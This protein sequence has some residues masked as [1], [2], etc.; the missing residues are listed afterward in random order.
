MLK[1]ISLVTIVMLLSACGGGSSGGNS[2]SD[3]VEHNPQE[4]NDSQESIGSDVQNDTQESNNSNLSS[5]TQ[6][7]EVIA[8]SNSNSDSGVNDC[9]DS[10][11][12]SY[13]T[14]IHKGDRLIKESQSSVIKV[15]SISSG[16]TKVCTSSGLA[17]LVR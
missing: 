7:I 5:D 2:S 4:L 8:C 10:D 12:E 6:K 11:R 17:Y 9:G 14:C 15:L 13:Y 16:T 3:V 1:I